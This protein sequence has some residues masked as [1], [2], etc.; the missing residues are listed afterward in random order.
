MID[1]LQEKFFT[2]P[3]WK[4]VEDM[5]IDKMN[6]LHDMGTI[7]KKQP[8]EHVKAEVIARDLAYNALAEFLN[9]TKLVGRKLQT[10]KNPF[11]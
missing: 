1:A 6:Q 2:D 4:R 5:L 3:D 8:A 10:R 9:E 7:D 11:I